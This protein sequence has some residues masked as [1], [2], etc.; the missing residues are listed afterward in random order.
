MAATMVVFQ[1]FTT[2]ENDIDVKY[3]HN[4]VTSILVAMCEVKFTH[5]RHKIG[6]SSQMH[7][8]VIQS[9]KN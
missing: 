1:T 5:N 3:W 2:S 7:Y 9:E 6:F 8:W 4:V